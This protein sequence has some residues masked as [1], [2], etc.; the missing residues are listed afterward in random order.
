MKSLQTKGSYEITGDYERKLNSF[1]GGWAS[2]ADTRATIN[3]VFKKH[4]YIIDTHTAVAAKVHNQYTMDTSDE[5]KAIIVST[6]AYKF[7]ENVLD[8]IEVSSIPSN[9][10][11][12]A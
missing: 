12:Q 11:E 1:V 6:A 7:V 5:S 9:D 3:N 2:V 4:N 10:Y 8:A